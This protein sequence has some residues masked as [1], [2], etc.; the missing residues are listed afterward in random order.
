MFHP[1]T[2]YHG[3]VHYHLIGFGITENIKGAV[4]AAQLAL[5]QVTCTST[6]IDQAHTH[7][8]LA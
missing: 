2:V 3:R 1:E 6:R 8:A 4:K 7:H 5:A